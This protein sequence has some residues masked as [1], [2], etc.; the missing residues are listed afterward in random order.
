MKKL[1]PPK[2]RG[3]EPVYSTPLGSAY[4]GD[5]LKLLRSLRRESVQAI[6]TSPPYALLTK[7]AYGNRPQHEYVDWFLQ[8]APEFYRVLKPDGSLLIEIGGTWLPGLPVRSIYQYELLVALVGEAD[9]YL[10]EEFFWFNRARLPGPAQWVTVNR[11]RAKDAVTPIWW[12]S[13]SPHPKADNRRV[14]KPYSARQMRL[15]TCDYNQGRRPSG[16]VIG[17]GFK[18]DNGGAIPPNFIEVANTRSNDP[19]QRYCRDRGLKA[20]PARFPREVPTFFVKFLTE[21][22]DTVLDPFAG[23]NT[24]GNVAEQLGR[25]WVAIDMDEDYV[26]SSVGRFIMDGVDV[27]S[28]SPNR[29]R[30]FQLVPQAPPRR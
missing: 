26:A 1:G 24:T 30:P 18:K 11:M 5:S 19:Y 28:P 17:A 9:F 12:L 15:F 2:I 22:G 7:K 23:S 10:A 6:I 29:A 20:H 4:C 16:H 25:R 8:F 3:H 27:T 21:P 13:K 14:L